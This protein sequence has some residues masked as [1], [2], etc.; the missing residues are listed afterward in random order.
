MNYLS[1][2]EVVSRGTEFIGD[3]LLF[4]RI[5]SASVYKRRY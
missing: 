2:D 1:M 5:W 4:G 3:C